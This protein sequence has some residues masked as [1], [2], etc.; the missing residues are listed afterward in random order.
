MKKTIPLLLMIL[1]A[2]PRLL[3]EQAEWAQVPEILA[4]IRPPAF[5]ARDFVI[6]DYGAVAGGQA[7][8]TAAIAK[9]IDACAAGGGG[10]VVVPSGGFLT[11]PIHLKSNVDLHL[12]ATNSTL[13]FS[14]NPKAYL[15]AVFT[16]V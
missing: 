9:A 13:K 15:P 7:D 11:G 16:P 10:H 12:A 3:A 14:T 8:C 6:T 2:T 5:P 1:L 4:R